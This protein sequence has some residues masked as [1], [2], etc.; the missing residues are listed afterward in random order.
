VCSSDLEAICLVVEVYRSLHAR[1]AAGAAVTGSHG[2]NRLAGDLAAEPDVPVASP[3]RGISLDGEVI[4]VIDGDTVEVQFVAQHRLRLMDC[5]APEVRLGRHTSEADKMRGL[6]A[7]SYLQALLRESD[8]HVRVFIPGNGG[9][10]S[11]LTHMSRL[12]GRMW[13][14]DVGLSPDPVDVS[15]LMV[16]SGHATATRPPRPM[17][18]VKV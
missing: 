10:I 2:I 7:K 13:R 9:D 11:R 5:W 3:P 16:Q 17:E 14:E 8:N 12:V 1:D 6:A 18:D 4:R 15:T